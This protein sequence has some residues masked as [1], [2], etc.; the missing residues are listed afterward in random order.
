MTRKKESIFWPNSLSKTENEIGGSGNIVHRTPTKN[1]NRLSPNRNPPIKASVSPGMIVQSEKTVP[2]CPVTHV[3]SSA[4]IFFAKSFMTNKSYQAYN[5][6][7]T[8]LLTLLC[9]SSRI[10]WF[11]LLLCPART[12][13]RLCGASCLRIDLYRDTTLQGL[14]TRCEPKRSGRASRLQPNRQAKLPVCAVLWG[15]HT[16]TPSS[17]Y[18][19]I[20]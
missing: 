17:I 7:S 19:F 2:V 14:P 1:K 10:R 20:L 13:D 5:S 3:P 11:S 16:S 8:K 9:R 4:S 18:N 6:T 15:F 12:T